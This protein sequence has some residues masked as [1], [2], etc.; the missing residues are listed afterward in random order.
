MTSELFN[1]IQQE[2]IRYN[3]G[4]L[5]LSV[6]RINDYLVV[7]LHGR[8]LSNYNY[9]LFLSVIIKILK[10]GI[11]K[12]A[13]DINEI[14]IW[15]R[16]IKLFT[17]LSVLLRIN[18][19]NL[20]VTKPTERSSHDWSEFYT[21]DVYHFVDDIEGAIKSKISFYSGEFKEIE[22]E[23]EL[24]LQQYIIKWEKESIPLDFIDDPR[25]KSIE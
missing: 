12:I 2:L 3:D 11:K 7:R 19:G 4:V 21:E 10:T 20:I 14:Q 16:I 22:T 6:D 15:P 17:R 1:A 13:F 25:I 9:E 23:P 5:T 24:L 8:E 18:N